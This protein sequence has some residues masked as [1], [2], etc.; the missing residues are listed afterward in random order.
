MFDFFG[1]GLSFFIGFSLF[2]R[3]MFTK[4]TYLSEIRQKRFIYL[5]L[6]FSAIF[7]VLTV[8]KNY[9]V[10]GIY[11][12]SSGHGKLI[13]YSSFFWSLLHS[14]HMLYIYVLEWY[15]QK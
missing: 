7:V 14:I 4:K 15:R 10:Y 5:T 3:D 11:K 1:V 12:F 6:I 8:I 13:I 9:H 2:L